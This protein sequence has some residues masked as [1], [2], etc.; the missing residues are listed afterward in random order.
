MKLLKS[1][2]EIGEILLAPR[3]RG[4]GEVLQVVGREVQERDQV[5]YKLRML[6]S[7][8]PVYLTIFSIGALSWSTWGR[9]TAQQPL[10]RDLLIL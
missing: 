2:M 1:I 7:L 5:I 8:A 10:E 3:R 6:D 9:W 4:G